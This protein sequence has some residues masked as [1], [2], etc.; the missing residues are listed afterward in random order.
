MIIHAA[1][2]QPQLL[3]LLPYQLVYFVTTARDQFYIRKKTNPALVTCSI[4]HAHTG[5]L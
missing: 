3:S 5:L 1:T 4:L 2:A